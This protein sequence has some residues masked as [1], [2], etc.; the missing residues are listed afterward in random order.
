M[1]RFGTVASLISCLAFSGF[2]SAMDNPAIGSP[3]GRGQVVIPAAISMSG[4]YGT[5]W[6]SDFRFFNPC[7]D[8]LDVHVEFQP[9]NT[10]NVG[11]ALV[12]R[13]FYLD[14]RATTVF[15]DV[16]ELLPALGGG[17]VSGSIRVQS[18]SINGCSV[19]VVSRTFNDTPGGTLG[20][21]VPAMPVD[22][23][24]DEYLEYPGLIHNDDYRTNLRLVNFSDA[25]VWVAVTAVD[26]SGVQVGD[27]RSAKVFGKSTKQINGVASWLGAL[28]D[29]A[30]FT[31]RVE[32]DGR[33]VQAVATVVDNITGDSVLYTSSFAGTS[34]LWLAGAASL[35][36]VNESQWRTDLWL[37]N[38]T[39]SLLD[40]ESEFFVGD[41]PNQSYPFGW[42]ALDTLST[43]SYLDVVS[44]ELGLEETRGYIVLTGDEGGPAPQVAARTYNLD[45]VAGTYG[46]NLR[47]YR[48]EDLLYPGERGHI[49][50]VSN[51]PDLSEGYRTN[52]GFLNTSSKWTTVRVTMLNLDGWS[53][54]DPYETN[55]PPG[56]LRQFNVYNSLGLGDVDMIGTVTFEVISGG[57]VAVY[58]TEIDNRTQDS[59]FIVAQRADY[60][61]GCRYF[62]DPASV[63]YDAS[64]GDGSF[65][66]V[67]GPDCEWEIE[68]S[69]FT[70]S[71]VSVTNVGPRR[72]GSGTVNYAVAPNSGSVREGVIRVGH[73]RF[74]IAQAAAPSEIIVS[75][76]GGV[77]MEL[78][79]IP[80]GTFQMGSPTGERGRRSNESLHDVTLTRGYFIGKHEVTQAQWAALMGSNPS[81][82]GGVGN[83]YPVFYVKWDEIAGPEGFIER[84]NEHLE[85][86]GQ[87][88]AGAFRLPTEAEWEM[89]ARAGTQTRFSYGDALECPDTD[90][91]PCEIFDQNMWWCGNTDDHTEPVGSKLPNAFGIYDMHGNVYEWVQDIYQEDLGT[92]PQTDPVGSSEGERRTTKGGSYWNEPRFDRA[93]VRAG[94]YPTSSGRTTGF[95]VA[96]S[97]AP[98]VK[99][100]YCGQTVVTDAYL[101]EDLS[102]NSNGLEEVAVQVGASNVT[103]DLGGYTIS[104]QPTAG[105][106]FAVWDVGGVTIKNGIIEDFRWGIDVLWSHDLVFEDLTIRNLKSDHP[107][108]FILGIQ[109]FR[110]DVVVRNSVFEFLPV[111][112]KEAILL[113]GTEFSIDSIE[114]YSGAGGVR[115]SCIPSD[116]LEGNS[117]TVTNSLF[118]GATIEAV[119]VH[120][121]QNVS[122]TDNEF[123]DNEVS[124]SVD[125][126]QVSS[127]TG[128]TVEGNSID[129]GFVGIHF[130]G[131]SDST[132]RDNAIHDTWRG[133]F[134]DSNMYCPELEC[135]Y[136]TDNLIS[137]NVVTGNFIDL[138]HHPNAT[139]NTWENNTCETKEGAEIPECTAR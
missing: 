62:L 29:L 53:A 113:Y 93:A 57:A 63:S 18:S 98:P 132:V 5:Q 49:V 19:T 14:R 11:V 100:T 75:L 22:V 124:V 37:Y 129:G 8:A 102:C 47:A 6:E 9:E 125:P 69:Q 117:G 90:C 96:R 33:E 55:V 74:H 35:S 91:E 58:A 82:G 13:N 34:Q 78:V 76:P 39:S 111:T 85:S 50:G 114:T 108:D 137:N 135:F 120:C 81:V 101:D 44:D 12:S 123:T 61:D 43:Q 59:M 52:L 42:P 71:W 38:P 138:F 40:G 77:S 20:L 106:A 3:S 45:P 72:I 118:D 105:I 16:F 115:L 32:A 130:W 87:S 97:L 73:S 65:S 122:I 51:S 139:G 94:G 112:H 89:A 31:V 24:E 27:S 30:P 25:T 95:R 104:G 54:A 131:N 10:D 67:T 41:D 60:A 134:L 64:G 110:S 103:V 56:K 109:T 80:P 68:P 26:E 48:G 121:A 127:L 70:S 136:A 92:D 17:E 83:E 4:A 7:S 23:S 15:S 21:T 36:G 88:G 66:V 99:I 28:E 128:L 116:S 79:Y 2:V 119:A 86:A 1:S 126:P 46:L 84:L 107:R 133:I